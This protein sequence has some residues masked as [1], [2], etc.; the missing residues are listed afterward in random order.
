M[1]GSERGSGKSVLAARH[2]EDDNF[3]EVGNEKKMIWHYSGIDT[4]SISLVLFFRTLINMHTHAYMH[5]CMSVHARSILVSFSL[6]TQRHTCHS[7][8]RTHTHLNTLPYIFSW[9]LF[10]NMDTNLQISGQY[11]RTY[12]TLFLFLSVSVCL[13]IYIYIYIYISFYIYLIAWIY[14][15][16]SY[17]IYHRYWA[18]SK[19]YCIWS[20]TNPPSEKMTTN[21]VIYIYIYQSIAVCIYL[22]WYDIIWDFKVYFS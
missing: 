17:I 21:T 22:L 7:H 11:V 10:I 12:P 8:S 14:S 15:S 2:D 13:C 5:L 3:L 6:N 9:T 16:L 18:L 4:F 20:A 1:T 19:S